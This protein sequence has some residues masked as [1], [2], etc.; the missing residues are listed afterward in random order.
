MSLNPFSLQDDF[1]LLSDG[2][3]GGETEDNTTTPTTSMNHHHSFNNL[4]TP[5]MTPTS[6]S[7]SGTNNS[8]LFSIPFS[9]SEAIVQQDASTLLSH[10]PIIQHNILQFLHPIQALFLMRA[11]STAWNNTVH[12][13]RSNIYNGTV[14]LSLL[15]FS[16]FPDMNQD[17]DE[18]IRKNNKPVFQDVKTRMKIN[19]PL[20]MLEQFISSSSS[21]SAIIGPKTIISHLEFLGL[22]IPEMEYILKRLTL[23]STCSTL[24]SS[25]QRDPLMS[26]SGPTSLT[27][28]AEFFPPTPAP[29]KGMMHNATTFQT[30]KI[31]SITVGWVNEKAVHN[32]TIPKLPTKQKSAAQVSFFPSLEVGNSI[33][34]VGYS[35]PSSKGKA[36]EEEDMDD[37]IEFDNDDQDYTV[38]E[39][40]EN[41]DDHDI[42]DVESN[43]L[44]ED[45]LASTNVEY[46]SQTLSILQNIETILIVDCINEN[47]LIDLETLDEH[48]KLEKSCSIDEV[49]LDLSNVSMT[50]KQPRRRLLDFIFAGKTL[51]KL[52]F[53]RNPFFYYTEDSKQDMI[54]SELKPYMNYMTDFKKGGSLIKYC[55]NMLSEVIASQYLIDTKF[56]KENWQ[57]LLKPLFENGLLNWNDELYASSSWRANIIQVILKSVVS[58]RIEESAYSS[59]LLRL[60]LKQDF[61]SAYENFCA[62]EEVA[63]ALDILE[64]MNETYKT[65]DG[66]L[67]PFDANR[68]SGRQFYSPLSYCQTIDKFFSSIISSINRN[69]VKDTFVICWSELLQCGKKRNLIELADEKA[70]TMPKKKKIQLQ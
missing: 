10:N 51:K 41:D 21:S 50:R 23:V 28:E 26:P 69:Q 19:Y 67:L 15:T 40:E 39:E 37:F 2:T 59:E 31:V 24:T 32:F 14:A 20:T 56:L 35:E 16:K 68:F 12:R 27:L 6:S 1:S 47:D 46:D 57:V 52:V 8:F 9:S 49:Q 7:T 58:Y 60:E 70:E 33:S 11:I 43:E 3:F 65:L 64:T 66:I 38:D 54:N 45:R 62:E 53:L 61:K 17:D 55:R 30:I 22:S 42:V 4:N 34:D 18:Y 5:L 63:L 48:C 44:D 25:T 36:E 29:I 13:L